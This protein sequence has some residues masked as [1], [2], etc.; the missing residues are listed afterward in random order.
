[1]VR[2]HYIL[3]MPKTPRTLRYR[4]LLLA[5]FVSTSVPAA[6]QVVEEGGANANSAAAY[7]ALS[8]SPLAGVP[9]VFSRALIA[10]PA[11]MGFRTHLGFTD[12]AGEVS[13][14]ML[15][16]GLDTPVG[17]SSL[18]FSL[19]ISDFSCNLD[20]L[21]AFGQFEG[22]C[23][24]MY[25]GAAAWTM[26]LVSSPIGA[27]GRFVLGFDA[28][29]GYTSGTEIIDIT[30]DFG[31]GPERLTAG[32]NGLSASMGLPMGFVSRGGGVAFVPHLAPRLGYGRSTNELTASG[33]SIGTISEKA[34]ESGAIFLLGGGISILFERPGLAIDLGF[35]KAFVKDAKVTIGLGFSFSPTR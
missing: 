18:G 5:L 24:S 34:T 10:K 35:Q 30:L 1:M 31:S 22:D 27:N 26:P 3:P 15:S 23:G 9:S 29:L 4:V 20:E 14:R 13:R 16:L 25:T 19:G 2:G 8:N 11:G 6:A 17:T 21:S 32:G 33:A 7:F 12:E 28:G